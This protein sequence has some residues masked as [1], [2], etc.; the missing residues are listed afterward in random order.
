MKQRL[1]KPGFELM[2]ALSITAIIGLPPLVFAQN[3]KDVEIKITNGDTL[4]NGK[5][6]KDL[7]AADRK[8]ALK[9]INN[10]G[11]VVENPG[12]GDKAF[13]QHLFIRKR[14]SGDTTRKRIIIRDGES[15]EFTTR[16]FVM[17]G[18]SSGRMLRF[19]F[20]R[21]NGKD[22]NFVFNYKINP[23]HFRFEPR[24]FDSPEGDFDRPM[25]RG[26]GFEMMHR[27]NSQNFSYSTTGSDGM[28]THINFSV[29]DVSPEKA[30][31]I[32]G[33]EK[34]ELQLND[35]SLVPE[36]TSGKTLL[37]FGLTGRGVAEVKFMDHEGKTI[38]SE[39]AVNG[40]FSKSFALGL[41]GVYLLE[42]KQA[43]KVALKRVIKEE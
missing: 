21:P 39:K 6:I 35:L 29:S 2:F 15:D 5:N 34:T 31:Q 23:D 36:F 19:K 16:D 10:L 18:D 38:W 41:N 7:S 42:V 17:R 26:R 1:I 13:Q 27:R 25:P 8:D 37:M 30:K 32:T 33:S 24:D 14:G 4:V 11:N 28:S 3:T 40:N 22:S 43:G 20:R 9:D 12:L